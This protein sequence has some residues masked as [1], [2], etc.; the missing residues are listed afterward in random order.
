MYAGAGGQVDEVYLLCSLQLLLANRYLVVAAVVCMKQDG[1]P[2][3]T[4][5]AA[6]TA[7]NSA[8]QQK[9]QQ[10]DR[11]DEESTGGTLFTI[12]HQ[13]L[14]DPSIITESPRYMHVD[15]LVRPRWI[16]QHQQQHHAKEEVRDCS[17]KDDDN[18]IRTNAIPMRSYI[19]LRIEQNNMFATDQYHQCQILL[20]K[21]D[22][23]QPKWKEMDSI[24]LLLKE[25][26]AACP[27]H[28]GLL[29]LQ[30]QCEE[31]IV[32]QQQ[33]QRSVDR[34]HHHTTSS[35]K[36][37]YVATTAA[38]VASTSNYTCKRAQT[39]MRDALLER[40][41]LLGSDGMK[42]DDN[43][44]AIYPLLSAN[45]EQPSPKQDSSSAS[46]SDNDDD[47]QSRG[48]SSMRKSEKYKYK[49]HKRRKRRRKSRSRSRSSSSSSS[50]S[51]LLSSDSSSYHYRRRKHRRK[52]KK[53]KRGE[54]RKKRLSR[55]REHGCSEEEEEAQCDTKPNEGKQD[56]A[57]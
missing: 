17:V 24:Q 6:T 57:T 21:L 39:A 9:M 43:T 32:M 28:E 26:I 16:L 56:D 27:N 19:G 53:K 1:T 55:H 37:P 4:S 14:R 50:L 12:L 29:S 7:T 33:Q 10:Q 31:W 15:G 8:Q 40:S 42:D 54:R 38:A 2:T 25:G 47:S 41:F 44:N 48:R 23:Q 13:K 52:T 51:S 34:S 30:K 49:K 45:V 3:Q 18:A 11:G 5:N 35:I 46:S 36:T 22:R 20:S